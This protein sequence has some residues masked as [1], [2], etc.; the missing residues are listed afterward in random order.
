MM[1][2]E[3][4]CTQARTL[5]HTQTHIYAYLIALVGI[6]CFYSWGLRGIKRVKE[7]NEE[8]RGAEEEAD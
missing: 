7:K 4:A 6:A 8:H 3:C 2:H 1:M 5:R